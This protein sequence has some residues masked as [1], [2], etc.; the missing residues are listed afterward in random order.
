MNIEIKINEFEGPLDLLLHLIKEAKMDIL[1]LKIELITDQY[2]DYINK[3]EKMNLDIAS[4]YLVMAAELIEMKSKLL[5]PKQENEEIEEPDPKEELVNRLIEYQKYK[6]LTNEFKELEEERQKIYT[7][8]PENINNYLD[9]AT[10]INNS[11]VTLDDLIDAFKKFLERQKDSEPLPTKVTQK[12]MSIEDRRVSIR[13]ILKE[14]KKVNFLELFDVFSKEY[15]VITFLAILEMAKVNELLIT[16]E[17]N[18]GTIMCEV[19]NE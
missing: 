2:L 16:Q 8:L 6:D 11:N 10:V 9:E 4:S 13:N 5:L 14:K 19:A 18:F 7:K 12:E 15:I 3:M 1:D 17:K